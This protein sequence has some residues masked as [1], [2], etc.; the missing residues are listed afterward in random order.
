VSSVLVNTVAGATPPSGPCQKK[1]R[2]DR[3]T[4]VRPSNRH[5]MTT[6]SSAASSAAIH[7]PVTVSGPSGSGT[8][9]EP[10]G[11]SCT[12]CVDGSGAHGGGSGHGSPPAPSRRARQAVRSSLPVKVATG[13]PVGNWWWVTWNQR[14]SGSSP[15][16]V[17]RHP[18][19]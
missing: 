11:L 6:W 14:V 2:S 10:P 5:S 12:V 15:L 17:M 1:S 7:R 18:V 3:S 13:V 9:A 4:V 8:E 19:A 16:M